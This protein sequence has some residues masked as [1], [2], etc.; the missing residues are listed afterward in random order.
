VRF[1]APFAHRR[2]GVYFL[3]CVFVLSDGIC[4][5]L[6]HTLIINKIR[7]NCKGQMKGRTKTMTKNK[8]GAIRG[9]ALGRKKSFDKASFADALDNT[10]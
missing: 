8:N 3:A 1:L 2:D 9:L 5:L 6:L 4:P 7:A 10:K